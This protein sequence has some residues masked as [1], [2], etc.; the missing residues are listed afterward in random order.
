MS[1]ARLAEGPATQSARYLAAEVGSLIG[2]TSGE[3][4]EALSRGMCGRSSEASSTS[5]SPTCVELIFFWSDEN[6]YGC[7]QRSQTHGLYHYRKELW[8]NIQSS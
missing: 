6:N 4:R 2:P 5:I 8:Q 7:H 1:A 3:C